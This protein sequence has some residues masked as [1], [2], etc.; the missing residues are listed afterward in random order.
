MTNEKEYNLNQKPEDGCYLYG[1]Y[2]EGGSWNYNDKILDDPIPKILFPELPKIWFIPKFGK[3]DR[4]DVN[5][6]FKLVLFFSCLY[7]F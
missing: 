7:N 1:F 5:K 3:V 6:F 2:L 4:K